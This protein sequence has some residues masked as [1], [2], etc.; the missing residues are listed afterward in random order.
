MSYKSVDSGNKDFLDRM[1]IP[2]ILQV[3]R[4]SQVMLRKNY[5]NHHPGLVNG[6]IGHVADFTSDVLS[7]NFDSINLTRDFKM[8]VFSRK[9]LK[10]YCP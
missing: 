1:L 9:C 2:R 6:L 3:R 8:E 5:M 7:V 10:K 4:G